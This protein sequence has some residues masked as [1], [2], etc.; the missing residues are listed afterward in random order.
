MGGTGGRSRGP[1]LSLIAAGTAA[2]PRRPAAGPVPRCRRTPGACH[3][4]PGITGSRRR[5]P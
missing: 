3:T 4:P 5:R 1:G 2:L